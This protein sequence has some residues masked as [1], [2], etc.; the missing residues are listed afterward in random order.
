MKWQKSSVPNPCRFQTPVPPLHQSAHYLENNPDS[1]CFYD[2]TYV[3]SIVERIL[4]SRHPEVS[5]VTTGIW[6]YFYQRAS[7]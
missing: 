7:K 1:E 3:S 2:N 6:R 4:M 5:S